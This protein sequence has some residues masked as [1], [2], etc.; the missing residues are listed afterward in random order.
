MAR[1]AIGK[2]SMVENHLFPIGGVVTVGALPGVM[3][4]GVV[5]RVTGLAIFGADDVLKGDIFPIGG[6]R[7]A[8]NA[9]PEI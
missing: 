6:I 3:V 9:R 7:V 4:V 2:A 1:L 5:L 8:V